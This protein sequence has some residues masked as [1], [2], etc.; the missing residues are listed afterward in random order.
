MTAP[1]Q[2][3]VR[4]Q[5]PVLEPSF[6]EYG[7]IQSVEFG[8]VDDAGSDKYLVTYRSGKQLEWFIRLDADGKVA[9]LLMRKAFRAL[10][11]SAIRSLG[12]HSVGF[13]EAHV[14]PAIR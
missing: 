7:P 14:P 6:K 11:V 12:A 2:E 8:G 13:R 1:L 9:G 4:K 10:G 3:A 5:L